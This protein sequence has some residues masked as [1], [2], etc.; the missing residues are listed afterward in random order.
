MDQGGEKAVE[1]AHSDA[2]SE[3]HSVCSVCE[4]HNLKNEADKKL[5]CFLSSPGIGSSKQCQWK[6]PGN[7]AVR[8]LSFHCWG[9]GFFI[10]IGEL[11]VG[12]GA[13]KTPKQTNKKQC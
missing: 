1:M 4:S 11:R 7:P 2:S 10:L 3:G 9:H 5:I 13:K 12:G 6:F 8:T